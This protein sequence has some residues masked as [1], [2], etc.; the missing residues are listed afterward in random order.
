MRDGA[1]SHPDNDWVERSP[2]FHIQRARVHLSLLCN[3]DRTSREDHLSHAATRL[4]MALT[5]GEVSATVRKPESLVET[6][7]RLGPEHVVEGKELC[8]QCDGLSPGLSIDERIIHCSLCHDA[9]AVTVEEADRCGARCGNS[10]R[11]RG[12]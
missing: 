12:R 8:P 4:L 9:H 6:L 11:K 10:R 1:A 2:E 3:G 5:L 7:R